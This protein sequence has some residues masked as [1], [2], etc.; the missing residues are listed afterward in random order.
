MNLQQWVYAAFAVTFL[1]LFSVSSVYADRVCVHGH[2]GVFED[3]DRNNETNKRGWG[4]DFDPVPWTTDPGKEERETVHYS[5]PVDADTKTYQ[6]IRIRYRREGCSLLDKVDIYSGER[7]VR[8]FELGRDLLKA[9]A[10]STEYL[11]LNL[12]QPTQ[13]WNGIGV[14]LWISGW[15]NWTD[16]P[17]K[18]DCSFP[19]TENRMRIYSVC[20]FEERLP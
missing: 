5:I 1:A 2:S 6:S 4:L 16:A 20:A 19:H 10:E 12:D 11:E 14:S 8:I 7:T 15:T 18:Y 3:P 13:F 17:N 9:E